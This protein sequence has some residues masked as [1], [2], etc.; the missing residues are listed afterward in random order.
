MSNVHVLFTGIKH[1][2]FVS[3]VYCVVGQVNIGIF[4]ILLTWP[5]IALSGKT[6]QPLL[7]DV[8]PHWITSVDENVDSHIEL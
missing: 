7:I 1:K 5:F 4:E 2:L 6:G 8:D 3:F